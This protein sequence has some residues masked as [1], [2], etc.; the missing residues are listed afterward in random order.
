VLDWSVGLDCDE[1]NLER[2]LFR[3][4]MADTLVNQVATKQRLHWLRFN[5]TRR[6]ETCD[7]RERHPLLRKAS[8][9]CFGVLG[10]QL[11]LVLVVSTIQFSR[12]GLGLDFSTSNQ[13]AYLMVHGQLLP[14]STVAGHGYLDDHFGLLLYPIALL[15]LAYPHGVLLLWLQDIAGVA[16]EAAV[17]V[18]VHRI[19]AARLGQ[20]DSRVRATA[21]AVLCVVTLLMLLN[22]WFYVAC[23]FDFH[24]LAFAALFLVCMLS[25]VWRA[26]FGWAAFWAG[27]LLLTGDT[28]GL[29]LVGAGISIAIASP[30]FKRRLAGVGALCIGLIWVVSVGAAVKA[31]I[32]L[33][34]YSWLI[35]GER[36]V[37]GRITISLLLKAL[38]QHPHRQIQMV[39]GKRTYLYKDLIPTGIIGLISPWSWGTDVMTFYAMAI[40]ISLTFLVNGFDLLAGF[41]VG[42][43]STA[44][45]LSYLMSKRRR[46][47]SVAVPALLAVMVAQSLA[48]AVSEMPGIPSYWFRVSSTQ[49]AVLG[50]V[51]DETPENAE[52]I[53]SDGVMGRFSGRHVI[54]GL[55]DGQSTFSLSEPT[56]IFVFSPNA[57]IEG[58]KPTRTDSAIRFV[59]STLHAKPLVGREGIYA[60]L[61]H[62]Q[63]SV[64]SVD[65]LPDR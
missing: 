44:M 41:L 48:L 45:V 23:L 2:G 65:L 37:P 53:A 59:R 47:L 8:R 3:V 60:F 16:G 11:V 57:G 12:F 4:N 62:P 54:Y 29:Y 51:L 27:A 43:V 38:V 6:L 50:K 13:A 5:S 7:V 35:S 34:N 28:G 10:A 1:R 25:N 19:L 64:H 46:W 36:G 52:V 40:A 26:K 15:Y 17:F 20:G 39:W 31:N 24:L 32:V 63:R 56:V 22:P 61:W 55:D 33:E 42:L 18:W 58:W 49:A 21:A 14:F 9:A 30:S